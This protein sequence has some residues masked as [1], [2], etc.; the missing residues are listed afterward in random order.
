MYA[1]THRGCYTKGETL[2]K[3]HRLLGTL[4][5]LGLVAAACGDDDDT[6]SDD[7]T[8]TTESGG[9]DAT[10]PGGTDSTEPDRLHPARRAR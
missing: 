9:T 2:R 10:E 3:R 6:G 7:G 5:V 4:L 8:E 1:S